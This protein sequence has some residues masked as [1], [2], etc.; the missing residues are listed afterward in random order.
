M[1]LYITIDGGTTNTRINLA[2]NREIIDSIRLNIGA[3]SGIENKDLLK[4][5]L[6]DAIQKILNCNHINEK[7]V[8]CILASGMI[9][10]EFGLYNLPHISTPAGINELHNSIE[11]VVL[12]DITNIPF[13]FIRGVKCMSERFGDCD[14]MRGEETELMGIVSS[15]YGKCIYI[16]PGSHSKIINTDENNR[17]SSFFTMLSGEM[18][19]AISQNTILKDAVDMTVRELDDSYL[20]KGFDYCKSEGINKA[21]FKVRILKNCF[22]C[23][24]IELYSFFIGIILCGEIQ[25]IIK[26]NAETVVIGG[27]NQ[28]K[29]AIVILL[30]N[31]DS[32]K[33]I[34]LD[35]KNVENSTALGA[36]RIFEKRV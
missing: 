18:I 10:S 31:R 7:D 22:N 11:Q 4:N 1:S 6:K 24:K 28:L 20:L 29:N 21:L 3:R 27:K 5:A 30:K 8:T 14:I 35:E 36:I 25:E 15:D 17:I 34:S 12:H 13:T 16:L 19:W 32:K 26:S 2:K 23:T 9:T 33:I